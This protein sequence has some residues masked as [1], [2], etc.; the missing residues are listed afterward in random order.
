MVLRW[1]LAALHLLGLGVGLGAIYA[2]SR[3]LRG[4]LD[5]SGLRRVFVADTWWGVAAGLWIVT[6]LLRALGGYE[7]GTDY[8]LH[9]HLFL[10]KMGLLILILI[11]ETGVMLRLILWRRAVAQ[12]ALPDTSRAARYAGISRL[13]TILV[14]LMVAAATGMARGFG[15]R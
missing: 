1:I 5:L 8:Y 15:A 4:P 9:N 7:K 10:T 13:Q 6:G 11:L 3:A 14:L 2:R 12:G